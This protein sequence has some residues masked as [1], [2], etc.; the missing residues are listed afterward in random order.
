MTIDTKGTVVMD[1]YA[2]GSPLYWK[3]LKPYS[4]AMTGST[5]VVIQCPHCGDDVELGDG[6]SGLFDCPYCGKDF[7]WNGDFETDDLKV[8]FL[9]FLFGT[10]SPSLLFFVSLWIMVAVVPPSGWDVL[11]YFGLSIIFCV[12]YTL[13]LAI[14]SGLTKNK[15]LLQGILLSVLASAMIIYMY[16]EVL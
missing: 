3:L 12:L 2:M 1:G 8:G 10:F 9:L 13:S 7:A 6:A 11:L 15:P 4:N 14:Y 5:M 16:T